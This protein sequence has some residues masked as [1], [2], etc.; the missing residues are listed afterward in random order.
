M[1]RVNVERLLLGAVLLDAEQN[2]D[3]VQHLVPELFTTQDNR[4]IAEAIRQVSQQGDP[5]ELVSVSLAC[6]S[7]PLAVNSAYIVECCQAVPSSEHAPYLLRVLTEFNTVAQAIQMSQDIIQQ[8]SQTGVDPRAVA[9]Q[10]AE[11]IQKLQSMSTALI[12]T[13]LRDILM[14]L[15]DQIQTASQGGVVGVPTGIHQLDRVLLGLHPGELTLVAARTSMGKSSFLYT[16]AAS[17]AQRS[18]HVGFIS[19]EVNPVQLMACLVSLVARV[20]NRA[21]RAGNMTPDQWNRVSDAMASVN[22]LPVHV[23]D[24]PRFQ[25]P[26][27]LAGAR[28]LKKESKLDIL[29]IDYIQLIDGLPKKY[30][31]R[32]TEVARI[33]RAL[34]CLAEDLHIPV[35]AAAQ[36]NRS[37]DR[38]DPGKPPNL[39]DLRESGALEQDAETVL[40]LHRPSYYEDRSEHESE[41][42]VT[43]CHVIVA[44][45]RY[46]PTCTC[47]LMFDRSCHHFY[48]S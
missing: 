5:V 35:V 15:T 8:A 18:Q 19:I 2:S 32:V 28:R 11:T 9:N 20:N 13:P 16:L 45:Q 39:T 41:A 34:K 6:C 29:M 14:R 17:I 30:E 31:N 24:G 4:R 27:V 1:S 40:F 22:N 23:L 38:H 42:I 48:E 10:A 25:L 44:K 33:S 47:H 36:V 37:G 43:P 46:G 7:G 12:L 21:L 3:V 26:D